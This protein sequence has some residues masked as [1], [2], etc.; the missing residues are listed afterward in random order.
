MEK[1]NIQQTTFWKFLQNNKIVIPIIQRDYAQG[2][3]GKERLREKFLADLKGALDN[4]EKTLKLDFVYGSIEKSIFN[5]LDGQQRLT[6][7]WLLHWYIAHKAGKLE[8]NK[9]YFKNFSYETRVSSQDFCERLSDFHSK[10]G[11]IVESIQKQTWFLSSWKQDP[12]IQAMLN[13]L[14]G[15]SIKKEKNE[16]IDGLEEVFENYEESKFIDYWEKLS[17]NCPITFYYLDLQGLKLSDDLYI[18]MNARGKPLTSFENFKADLVGYINEKEED[19]KDKEKNEGEESKTPQGSIAHKL[20]V[21]WTNIFWENKS[22]EPENKIDEI[23]FAFINRFLLNAL[24]TAKESGIYKYNQENIEKENLFKH[25]YDDVAQ[26]YNNFGIY[27]NE[28]S[29]YEAIK[30]L[31][32][33]LDNFHK[34]FSFEENKE[35]L[36]SLF[37]P[38]WNKESI[39]CFIP[40]YNN[41]EKNV[42][43]VS[44]ITQSQRVIFYAIC[45]YFKNGKYQNTSLKNWMRVVWNI[46]ENG[47]IN[48]VSS[49]VGAMRLINELGEYSHNIYEHLKDR[50]VSGDFAKEQMS[51]EKAKIRQIING[52]SEWEEK[53]IKAEKTAFFNGAIRFLFTDR[54]EKYNWDL[55]DERYK[56]T[57]EYFNPNGV[58]EE[59]LKDSLLLRGF[60][61]K[62]KKFDHFRNLVYDNH[63]VTWKNILLNNALLVVIDDF[64]SIENLKE[65]LTKFNSIIEGEKLKSFQN[66]LCRT[67][68]LASIGNGC[69]FHWCNHGGLYSLYPKNTKSKEKIFV[70]AEKR[71]EILSTLRNDGVIEIAK[72]QKIEGL[73]YYKGWNIYFE[74]KEY[75][76]IWNTEKKIS[77]DKFI[78]LNDEKY[79]VYEDEIQDESSLLKKLDEMIDSVQQL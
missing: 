58:T 26:E 75:S 57:E 43:I 63:F 62:F 36:K 13:M 41:K 68:L 32:K 22:P 27:R 23:Y 67:P 16:I 18:K 71:N 51:E 52:G 34:S 5:P 72:W 77:F 60:I 21:D 73:P 35:C 7:L 25:I 37:S 2:R 47:N 79:S 44:P 45:C 74:Y 9:S 48:N 33:T 54:D 10:S 30:M 56:K 78:N 76:F 24:I 55:F 53:I 42:Y 20:D 46:V 8:E 12:T 11:K 28:F 4:S 15:T 3:I 38:Y 61:S 66:D 29:F 69:L 49:M 31:E 6:T 17:G 64:F 40:E 50:D 65:N 59:Y 19:G 1:K 14:G 70:L 39:F